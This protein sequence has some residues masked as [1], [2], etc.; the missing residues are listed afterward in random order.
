MS[1]ESKKQPVIIRKY[2]NRRL[3]NTQISSY[4]TLEDLCEMVKRG[5]DFTVKDAKTGEDLTRS[6]LTQIIFEQE[7]KGEFLL[8][9]EF[10]K[11][12]IGFYDD[13]LNKV[14]PVY[15]NKMMEAFAQNQQEMKKNLE[16]TDPLSPFLQFGDM[17]K[18]VWDNQQEVFAKT[19]DIFT[20]FSPNIKK[21]EEK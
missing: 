21:E 20:Q 5:E 1:K 6:V 19:M 15:L 2:E 3:Y 16:S 13:N 4:V 7:A 12:I 10:L 18:S 11:S 9:E 14:V 17:Y 8:P